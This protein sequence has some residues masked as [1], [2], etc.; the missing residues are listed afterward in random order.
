MNVFASLTQG[1]ITA[2]FYL[3][4]ASGE[5]TFQ[6]ILHCADDVYVYVEPHS[7]WGE[8]PLS[9]PEPECPELIFDSDYFK[10]NGENWICP[11]EPPTDMWW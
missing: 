5:M 11:S 2:T 4:P 8:G 1:D 6:Q 9:E 7:S 10:H 3:I